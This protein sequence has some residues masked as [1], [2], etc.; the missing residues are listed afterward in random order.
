MPT[1][2]RKL[3]RITKP[4]EAPNTAAAAPVYNNHSQPRLRLVQHELWKEDA[5]AAAAAAAAAEMKSI[6]LD[7]TTSIRKASAVDTDTGTSTSMS[8][9]DSER[10]RKPSF[11]VV[12]EAAPLYNNHS[13]PHL[14]RLVQHELWKVDAP[15]TAEMKS[16][17]LVNT[18][19]T[20]RASAVDTDTGTSTS[21]RS[22]DSERKRKSSFSAVEELARER[23]L[24]LRNKKLAR[25]RDLARRN[26]K[27]L[28]SAFGCTNQVAIR[29]VCVMHDATV[30]CS[31]EGC[32]YVAVLGGMCRGKH[33]AMKDAQS[34]RS[35]EMEHA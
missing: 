16:I 31:I 22:V 20:R 3:K 29:G 10:K 21:M 8:S 25:E 5:P 7:N 13:Q 19:S 11:S 2:I 27:K 4:C 1:L 32:P 35:P 33:A 26:K 12:E 30:K 18:T 15:A 34:R 28:C 6:P 17:P 24:A 9:A 14:R 23:V